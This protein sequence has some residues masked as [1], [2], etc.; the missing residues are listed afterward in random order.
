MKRFSQWSLMSIL[1]IV[2]SALILL[3]SVILLIRIIA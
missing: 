1:T 2:F 3:I